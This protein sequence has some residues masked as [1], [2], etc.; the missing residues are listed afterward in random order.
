F[1]SLSSDIIRIEEFQG[2]LGESPETLAAALDCYVQLS[3]RIESVY[4]YARMRS[5]TDLANSANLGDLDRVVSL[6]SQAASI[7]SFLQPE[8]LAIEPEIMQALLG[9]PELIPYR[10]MIEDIIRYRPHT[11]SQEQ[12]NIL[13]LGGEVF[14]TAARIFS[15]LN[16]A[17]FQFGEVSVAG[18]KV[19]L[20]H[21]SYSLLLKNPHRPVRE[22]AYNSYYSVYDAHKN[23]LAAALSGS[24]KKDVYFARV[25]NY[26]SAIE[27]SLFA[28]D[29]ET[30]VYD[31]LISTVEDNLTGLHEYYELR[32][33]VLKLDHLRIYDTYVPLIAEVKT[34][35]VYE[36]AVSWIVDALKP[37]GEDYCEVMRSGLLEKRWVDRY[38][39]KGK[40]SGAYSSGGYDSMPYILMNYKEDNLNDVFTLAHEAGHSMHSYYS[41]RNQP[42]QD[43]QYTIFVAEVA[44]TFNEQLLFKYLEEKYEDDERMLAYLLNEQIDAIKGTLF[45]QTMFAEFEKEI[46]NNFESGA[47]L[48]VDSYRE[49]YRGLLSKYFG[50]AVKL[51]DV[52]DLEC[53]RIPHFYSAFYVYKYATGLAAAIKLAKDVSSG[54]N[55]S[56]ERFLDF[57]S[58]GCSKH[59]LD[60]L[61]DA[62][63]DLKSPKPVESAVKE[64]AILVDKLG[65]ILDS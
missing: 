42:F 46:H 49:I 25:R 22:E 62:G 60:L 20:T 44:S 61:C 50:A 57:L 21:A 32:K 4:V 55:A 3:R 48:T 59:P 36:E 51:S 28:D 53:F 17:D 23:A 35:T 29:V 18:E 1:T 13:A 14:G 8:L 31:S 27:M 6:A 15:Q 41:I 43:Y 54:D 9:D 58:S 65:Q 40:R 52:D 45:R 12:E 26:K 56:K 38:E 24:V 63:V 11:L 33:R 7:S 2:R 34:K 16:N 39:N 10:R 19:P 5:D 64:L 30:S 47:P 37:L